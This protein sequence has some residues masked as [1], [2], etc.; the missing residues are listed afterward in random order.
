MGQNYWQISRIT[1]ERF[2]QVPIPRGGAPVSHNF[3]GPLSTPEWSE[4]K[5][6][7]LVR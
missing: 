1:L 3:L 4:L 7:N 5:R 6:P 2:A